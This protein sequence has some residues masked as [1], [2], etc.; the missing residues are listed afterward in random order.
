LEGQIV[1]CKS[2]IFYIKTKDKNIYECKARGIL[3][4]KNL[5]PIVGDNV[6]IN[7][8]DNNLGIIEKIIPRLTYLKRPPI[9]NITQLLLVLQSNITQSDLILLDKQIVFL[10]S[11]GITPVIC[12]NKM[13]LKIDNISDEVEKIYSK[14]GYRILK[15]IAKQNLGIEEVKEILQKNV[16]ALSG[17]SGVG[18]STIINAIFNSTITEEGDLGHKT[19]RG[20]H[21]TREIQIFEI[22][23]GTCVADTPRIFKFRN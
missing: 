17:N 8:L 1:R 7:V 21:T 10:E 18:K 23:E 16:T 20:K 19:D 6:E 22:E 11:Q 12:I 13:D 5:K 3:K 9:A 2:D 14:I 4:N 15:T